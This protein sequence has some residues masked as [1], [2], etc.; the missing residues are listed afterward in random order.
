MSIQHENKRE[1][2]AL[3]NNRGVQFKFPSG[4]MV[5]IMFGEHNY[6]D[7]ETTESGIQSPDTEVA[8]ILV[9]EESNNWR[10]VTRGVYKAMNNESLYDDVVGR[11]DI[12]EVTKVLAFVGAADKT[13]L[14]AIINYNP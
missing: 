5:S 13:T 6:C 1:A 14:E 2:F 3:M 7:S 8:I 9:N 11:V 10:F 12:N 4:L